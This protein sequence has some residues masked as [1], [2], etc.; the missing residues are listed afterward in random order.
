M[1]HYAMPAVTNSS[2]S[3]MALVVPLSPKNVVAASS[4]KVVGSVPSNNV[5]LSHPAASSDH[6]TVA[7][8][9]SAPHF[10]TIDL[11]AQLPP[12]S[13][14]GGPSAQ[15]TGAITGAVVVAAVV[16]L[17]VVSVIVITSLIAWRLRRIE[18]K[19]FTGICTVC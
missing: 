8:E 18:G 15:V 19:T 11:P 2:V 14:G 16:V 4:G 3:S 7:A 10:S 12:G 6:L 9:S 1:R 17:V 5:V 13:V